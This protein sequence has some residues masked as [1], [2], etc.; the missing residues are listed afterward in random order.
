VKAQFNS[1]YFSPFDER[2]F[3]AFEIIEMIKTHGLPKELNKICDDQEKGPLSV[4]LVG[5]LSC[6]LRG[7]LFLAQ[8]LGNWNQELDSFFAINIGG[9][10]SQ[11]KEKYSK[12]LFNRRIL[13]RRILSFMNLAVLLDQAKMVRLP[14]EEENFL[15][16]RIIWQSGPLAEKMRTEYDSLMNRYNKCTN[17]LI[18]ADK[19]SYELINNFL[20]QSKF[21]LQFGNHLYSRELISQDYILGKNFHGKELAIRMDSLKLDRSDGALFLLKLKDPVWFSLLNKHFK[22]RLYSLNNSGAKGLLLRNQSLKQIVSAAVNSENRKIQPYS[23]WCR[24]LTSFSNNFKHL[25]WHSERE[26][27]YTEESVRKALGKI[28]NEDQKLSDWTLEH[29]GQEH[30]FLFL[31]DAEQSLSNHRLSYPPERAM[32]ELSWILSEG[33]SEEFSPQTSTQYTKKNW[34]DWLRKAKICNPPLFRKEGAQAV[35]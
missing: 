30:P 19:S 17:E 8:W 16:A 32:N 9:E 13:E 18:S 22:S 10:Y 29:G 27:I 28:K 5:E 31:K 21:S 3:F 34:K 2:A 25:K 24:E 12:L 33:F 11:L 7:K 6:L 20:N 23:V 15:D 4:T 1:N 35:Y 14:S 26:G